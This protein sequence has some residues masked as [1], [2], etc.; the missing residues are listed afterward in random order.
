MEKL[1]KKLE[2][3]TLDSEEYYP[4]ILPEMAEEGLF[5]PLNSGGFVEFHEKLIQLASHEHGV[6]LGVGIMAQINIAG[7]LLKKSSKSGHKMSQQVLDE[8]QAGRH[9]VS[10]GVSEPGWKGRLSNIKSVLKNVDGKNIIDVEK[11][12]LTNGIHAKTFLVVVKSEEAGEYKLVLLPKDHPN[13]IVTKFSLPFAKEATHCKIS[14]KNLEI[15][16]EYIL[17]VPYK[18]YAENLR[19]SEMLSLA[20]IFTG[21]GIY[22][23]E[24]I[25]GND[26]LMGHIKK[27]KDRPK[28]Y[29]DS[30]ILLDLL[31]AR[32]L[33]LSAIKDHNPDIE[34]KK[35]FPYGTETVSELFLNNII[36]IFSIDL[37][38]S[39]SED[40][41]LFLMRD[42][43]NEFYIH[44][45]IK[46]ELGVK[47][48]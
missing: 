18:K 11:S 39:L 48:S 26:E 41:G 22:L 43:L 36:N 15:E 5:L 20:A 38:R 16:Q 12:F 34:L 33:E 21:F 40:I 6:G 47:T 8:I 3:L 42:P 19:L 32:V 1:F 45:A 24:K 28:R 31:R 9:V 14:C 2:S 29:L 10:M 37:V 13:L 4:A 35:Y 25:R 7:E 30:K 17:D 46:R 44:Q 23:L 27:E